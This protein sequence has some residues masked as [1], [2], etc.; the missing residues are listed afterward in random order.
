MQTRHT[1][2]LDGKLPLPHQNPQAATMQLIGSVWG[3][4]LAGNGLRR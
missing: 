3:N 1:W 2:N 4:L